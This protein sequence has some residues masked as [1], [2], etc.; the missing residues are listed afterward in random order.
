M[1]KELDKKKTRP[2]SGK[3]GTSATTKQEKIEE[4]LVKQQLLHETETRNRV[5]RIFVKLQIGLDFLRSI[6]SGYNFSFSSGKQEIIGLWTS[7]IQSALLYQLIIPELTGTRPI[8]HALAGKKAVDLFIYLG[9]VSC[10]DDSSLHSL[11]HPRPILPIAILR[12]LG[13]LEDEVIGLIPYYTKV[14][15]KG[16]L[17]CRFWSFIYFCS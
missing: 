11:V 14:T 16:K 6:L 12:A 5:Q 9:D 15:L 1:R 10:N 7:K 17:F 4:E 2:P 3:K 13:V 8:S